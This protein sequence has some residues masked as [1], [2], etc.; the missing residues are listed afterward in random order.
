MRKV[1]VYLSNDLVDEK[2]NVDPFFSLE[3]GWLLTHFDAVYVV[4]YRGYGKLDGGAPKLRRG[5]LAQARAWLRAPF[6]VPY[7]AEK[8]R[9]KADGKASLTGRIKLLLFTVRGLKMHLWAERVLRNLELPETSLYSFWLS[10]DGFAAALCKQKHAVLHAVARGHAFEIDLSR[11][12]MNPYLMKD[13]ICRTLDGV[14][15]ISQ[16]AR[17]M[18]TGYL[19]A[20]DVVARLKVLSVGSRVENPPPVGPAPYADTGVLRV[21]SCSAISKIKRLSLLIEALKGFSACP[22]LWTHIGGGPD[23]AEV[24]AL[25]QRE[26]GSHPLVRYEITGYTPHEKVLEIYRE[27]AFDVFINVSRMEG[28]PVSIM[29]AMAFG[30]PTVAP[31]LGGIPELVSEETGLL[32]APEGGAAAVLNALT[33]F[34]RLPP[35][36]MNQMRKAAQQRWKSDFRSEKLLP[37]LFETETKEGLP[38]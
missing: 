29:E 27:T 14:F 22:V 12:L 6:C 2:G 16:Y 24:R 7:R 5:G 8:R 36:K 1:C 33:S 34:A 13:F 17:S 11:N 23:E 32:F 18:L 30:V 38:S 3:K 9:L 19:P 28:V 15:L 10:Y 4:C 25:A 26:L 20:S 35:E 31:A 37:G 21:V